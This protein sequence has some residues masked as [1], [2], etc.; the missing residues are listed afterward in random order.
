MCFNEE[1]S[2]GTFIIG[3]VSSILCWTIGTP[4]YKI[5]AVFFIFV[6]LMQLI[7]FFLW[8]NQE[9]NE[10]NKWLSVAGM[11]LNH[12]QPLVLFLAVMYFKGGSINK[13]YR[14]IMI[15]IV[16]VYIAVIIPYSIEFFKTDM[17]TDKSIPN[18]D[19]L[20]WDWNNMKYAQIV[21][22]IFLLSLLI[23]GYPV[24]KIF[25]AIILIFFIISNLIYGNQNVVGSMWCFF[26]AF[27][28]LFYYIIAK[29]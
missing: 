7:E 17:C 22:F 23:F 2:I 28:P 21:Y 13:Q 18:N 19:H 3:M 20:I 4:E 1:V 29:I 25:S 15:A 8:R 14:K 24:N 27:A 6:I 12:L 9:C 10:T 16:L 26:A 11:L 5:I